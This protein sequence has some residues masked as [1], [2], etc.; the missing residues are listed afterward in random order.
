LDSTTA[1]DYLM[2]LIDK[3]T[4]GLVPVRFVAFCIVGGIGVGVHFAALAT[5]TRVFGAT[6]IEGQAAATF[7]AMTFNFAI[8]NVLTYRDR[9]LRGWAWLRGWISF[10]LACSVG[11]FANLA[12]SKAMYDVHRGW[13]VAAMTGVLVGAV[14][15][16]AITTMLTWR[17]PSRPRRA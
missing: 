11:G 3:T 13:V 8:N 1:W 15:N 5:I 10:V 12:A 17:R 16:Y 2:L 6:F 4:G 14:W 9:Q 7:C